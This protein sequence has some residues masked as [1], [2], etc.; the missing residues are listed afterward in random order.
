MQ[1]G[2]ALGVSCIPVCITLHQSLKQ[3][4]QLCG[5]LACKQTLKLITFEVIVLDSTEVASTRCQFLPKC[6]VLA[7]QELCSS[8][9]LYCACR[10]RLTLEAAYYRCNKRL[11][12]ILFALILGHAAK[13][14]MDQYSAAI[15]TCLDQT[16]TMK[17][18][19]AFFA[20]AMKMITTLFPDM[21]CSGKRPFHT[22]RMHSMYRTRDGSW[23]SGS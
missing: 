17:P 21:Y 7:Y 3:W 15:K 18:V 6:W 2:H 12:L 23:H 19:A 9:I 16:H 11:G 13:S 22:I 4:H 10:R 8:S 1:W 20:S 5:R 14:W